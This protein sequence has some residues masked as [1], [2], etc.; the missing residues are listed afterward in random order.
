[1]KHCV[2]TVKRTTL[3]QLRDDWRGAVTFE[4]ALEC[5]CRSLPGIE[6]HWHSQGCRCRVRK[7]DGVLGNVGGQGRCAL[8]RLRAGGTDR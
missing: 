3:T 2:S 5:A 6:G 8:S 4:L 7:A 1:M